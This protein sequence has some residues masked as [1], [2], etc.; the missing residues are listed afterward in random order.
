MKLQ[1]TINIWK[2]YDQVSIE[3]R[4]EGVGR[5]DFMLNVKVVKEPAQYTLPTNRWRQ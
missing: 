1:N 5:S 2:K 3:Y 4:K